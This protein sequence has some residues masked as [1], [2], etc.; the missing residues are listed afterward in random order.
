MRQRRPF[1]T[2]VSIS[3]GSLGERHPTTA[4]A[5]HTLALSLSPQGKY[6]EADSMYEKALA[7]YR[8]VEDHLAAATCAG[9]LR[10]T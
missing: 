7:I 10:A 5:Y 1:E 3:L 8:R 4:D 6:V 9:N 2:R